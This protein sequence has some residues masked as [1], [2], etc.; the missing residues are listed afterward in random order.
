MFAD[1]QRLMTHW[2]KQGAPDTTVHDEVRHAAFD[3]VDCEI[4]KAY[5][6]SQSNLVAELLG[7]I[8]AQEPEFFEELVIDILLAM[9]YGGRRRD[10]TRRLG[11]SG[12]GGVDGLISMD[13]LGLDLI[14]LQAKRL[15]PGTVV[16]VT[17]V[18]DFAGSL[19]ANHAVKGIFLT[20]SHFSP[21]AVSFCQQVSR[22]VVL[23]DG[24]KFAEMMIRHNVGVR[25]KESYQL[26]RIDLEYFRQL[27][28][29]PVAP[30]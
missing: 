4:A 24:P 18:R 10:L 30:R 3:A 14:Y 2:H 19:D 25:V 21:S 16:P 28:R 12:D 29:P 17:D 8:H 11:R 23:V 27:S 26:K 5:T 13:E 9:G 1:Y 22:R 7:H 20:T 15:K 6:R